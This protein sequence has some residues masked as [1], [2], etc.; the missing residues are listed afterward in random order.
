MSKRR[1]KKK[2]NN[3]QQTSDNAVNIVLPDSL[4][5]QELQTIITN[6]M[7][8]AEKEKQQKLDKQQEQERSELQKVLGQKGFKRFWK[9]LFLPKKYVKGDKATFALLK[10]LA[11]S[12]FSLAKVLTLLFSLLAIIYIPL[13]FVLDFLPILPLESSITWGVLA[14][15][16]FLLSRI[17]RMAEIEVEKMEDRNMLFSIFAS[18]ISIISVIVAMISIVK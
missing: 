5:A 15:P 17:F 1:H 9:I 12:I 7:V 6:A 3:N 14:V 8:E 13:Q 16:L 2:N 18:I 10:V 4:T 11:S